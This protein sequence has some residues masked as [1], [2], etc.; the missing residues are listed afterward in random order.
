MRRVEARPRGEAAEQLKRVACRLFAERGVD[1]VTVREIADAAGQKN[2]GAVGYYFGS[3]EA[4]VR[5]LLIDGAILIDQNRHARIA[6]LEAKG[7]PTRVSEVVDILTETSIDVMGH[8]V[9]EE[10]YVRFVVM[11]H[12]THR[13]LFYDTVERKWDKGYKRC[14]MHLRRLM[15]EM[16]LEI[17]N[18]RILFFNASLRM[19]LAM[20]EGALADIS[21]PHPMWGSPSSLEHLAQLVT[22]MLE[23]PYYK[24]D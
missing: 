23:A 10:T 8:P 9:H 7:G 12:M 17:K 11:L 16:P 18:Q 19:I 15:P 21:R 13:K 22:A 2:H 1:G 4:L 6:A 5:E 20:R 14:V 3:K 24:R